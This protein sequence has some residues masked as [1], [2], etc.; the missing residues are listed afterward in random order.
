MEHVVPNGWVSLYETW[1]GCEDRQCLLVH[2]EANDWLVCY[3]F[4]TNGDQ[5]RTKQQ[6]SITI[7][8]DG[9]P[10]WFR[11]QCRKWCSHRSGAPTYRYSYYVDETML[12]RDALCEPRLSLGNLRIP[13]NV[14]RLL[15]QYE[16]WL[17]CAPGRWNPWKPRILLWHPGLFLVAPTKFCAY[18][19]FAP[20][21]FALQ[22]TTAYALTRHVHGYLGWE[23]LAT[24]VFLEDQHDWL[25]LAQDDQQDWCLYGIDN[26]KEN[27]NEK[28]YA[29]TNGPMDDQAA[30][31]RIC[32]YSRYEN[33]VVPDNVGISVSSTDFHG[34]K[35]SALRHFLTQR[36]TLPHRF[37]WPYVVHQRMRPQDDFEAH[38]EDEQDAW[39]IR[40]L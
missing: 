25:V 19:S 17:S 27:R 29:E 8:N 11:A 10:G 38:L 28:K 32:R 15:E 12:P 18:T 6:Q 31:V 16:R 2:L 7:S 1:I 33:G 14:R 13:T 9:V 34:P 26:D 21:A 35:S 22:P 36:S 39:L 3:Q 40:P 4:R 24:N 30:N 5:V 37:G 23:E 20:N